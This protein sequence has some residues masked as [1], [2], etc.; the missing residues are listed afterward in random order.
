VC[1]SLAT[2]C[3]TIDEKLHAFCGQ[4]KHTASSENYFIDSTYRNIISSQSLIM[5]VKGQITNV[6]PLMEARA[7]KSW[8]CNTLCK[9]DDPILIDRYK[10]FH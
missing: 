5:N 3:S 10:E 9:I 7:K 4:S 1:L 6:L 2:K 8:V